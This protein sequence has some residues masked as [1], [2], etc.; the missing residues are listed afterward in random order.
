MSARPHSLASA[1]L[2]RTGGAERR[3]ERCPGCGTRFVVLGRARSYPGQERESRR[4]DCP[5]CH[6]EGALFFSGAELGGLEVYDEASW[7]L[8]WG[9]W[10]LPASVRDPLARR[11]EARGARDAAVRVV[12][13]VLAVAAALLPLALLLALLSLAAR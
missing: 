9:T 2:D 3:A 12:G 4:I 8:L 6:R 7:T 5:R 1:C 11:L 13:A 10:W